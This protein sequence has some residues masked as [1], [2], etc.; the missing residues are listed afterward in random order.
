MERPQSDRDDATDLIGSAIKKMLPPGSTFI[1]IVGMPDAM[2][3]PD[4]SLPVLCLSNLHSRSVRAAVQQWLDGT[5]DDP[6]SG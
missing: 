6:D 1:L 3:N 5:K 4:G 2:R